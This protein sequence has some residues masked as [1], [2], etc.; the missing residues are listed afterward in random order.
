LFLPFPS[1][2]GSAMTSAK[3]CLTTLG[4]DRPE[5]LSPKPLADYAATLFST[6][7]IESKTQLEQAV[8]DLLVTTLNLETQADDID[9]VAP[10]FG[11]AGLGLDSIDMLELSLGVSK[12]YGFQLRSDAANN[13]QIFASLRALCQHIDKNCVR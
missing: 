8:A 4:G 12:Q 10:L 5:H 6:T 11:D 9:P 13:V 3:S 2:N 1:G 7:M